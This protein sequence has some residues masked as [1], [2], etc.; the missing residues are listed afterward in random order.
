MKILLTG[1]EPFNGEKI[2]SAWEAVQTLREKNP[3]PGEIITRCLP[4]VF[5]DGVEQIIAA[6]DSI[7][8]QLIICTGQAGGRSEIC[9]ERAALNIADA[10]IRDNQGQ[11]PRDQPVCPG[12]PAAYWSTLP[13]KYMVKRIGEE[14]I[15]ARISNSAG[16]YVCNEVMYGVLYHLEIKRIPARAGLIHIPFL[17]QQAIQRTGTPSMALETAVRGLEV[18]LQSALMG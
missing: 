13:I 11:Q 10:E 4:T 1:F 12:G 15:P 7:Q 16:T 6:V 9:V 3:G 17:P 14:G 5:G 8:P 18:A 2:N